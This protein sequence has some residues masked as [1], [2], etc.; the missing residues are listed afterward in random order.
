MVQQ[1]GY[2]NSPFRRGPAQIRA[3]DSAGVSVCHRTSS[4]LRRAD[5]KR[6][7]G[8]V[9]SNSHLCASSRSQ[10]S[11]RSWLAWAFPLFLKLTLLPYLKVSEVSVKRDSRFVRARLFTVSYLG[12][13]TELAANSPPF[14][15]QP[16]AGGMSGEEG[17]AH[18]YSWGA[19]L[20]YW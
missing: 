14:L 16:D 5:N 10:P 3:C 11:R 20:T 9:R 8:A 6:A 2:R 19:Y 13:V 4:W 15:R 17:G 1:L 7:L 12:S 18:S